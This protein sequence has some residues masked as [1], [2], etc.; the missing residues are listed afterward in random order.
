ML[1]SLFLLVS[2]FHSPTYSQATSSLKTANYEMDIRLDIENKKLYGTTTLLWNNP[3]ADEIT[4]LPMHLYYN[5]FRNSQS[6]FLKERGVPDFLTKNIDSECGWGW[7]QIV[8]IT[9]EYGNDLTDGLHYIQTDD[10]NTEDKS[11]IKIPLANTVGPYGSLSVTF[12][13][14]AKIP[15]T[16]P[17]TG[18]NKDFY[19]FAQWF[20][21]V[22][23][24]EPA[25]TRYAAEGAWNCHQ[26]HSNGEYYSDF[27]VY[28][29]HL[30]VP[31][32]YIVAASGALKNTSQNGA[33]K[34]WNFVVENVID[35]TW[36]CSPHYVVTEDKY[37]TTELKVY[38]YPEKQHFT[39]RYL[40]TIKFTMQYLEEHLGPYPYPTL[41]IIDPPI[42]G[43]YTGGMEYPTLITCLSFNSF[44]K[45]FKTPETLI[46]HEYIHQYFMQMVATHE[47]EE[48]WM[49]EGF[50]TYYEGRILDAYMTDNTSTVEFLGLKAGNKEWNRAEFFGNENPQ[51][52]ANTRKSWQYKHGGYGVISYNKTA[53][54]LQT[55]ER[56][57]GIKT[58]DE[59][60]KTY[61][62]RWQYKH[63]A[64]QDYIDIVNEVVLKNHASEYPKGMD[65]YFDQVL[66][67][68]GL[69]DYA[70][71][72][73]ENLKKERVR[74]YFSDLDHCEAHDVA[75]DNYLSTIILHRLGEIKIPVD[76]QV[77]LATGESTLYSWDGQDRSSEI[78]IEGIEKVV[79]V[80]IDPER[81]IYLDKNFLNNSLLIE[82]QPKGIRKIFARL[83]TSTLHVFETLAI[84]I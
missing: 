49:D 44:P 84:L 66:Y 41:S 26:Y 39:D 32:D 2:L 42:H 77:T 79:S 16:M 70:V 18:Y 81:K 80:E 12:D 68:T 5:A 3:S 22:G 48:P 63:P 11:V 1:F 75:D 31:E 29:V 24:Y 67:G 37:K 82:K 27:G 53:L 34:T 76:V 59:I 15:Q 55:M 64:R 61:F 69:C 56:L 23:V 4:Y 35:F 28:D 54:W 51:I 30:T 60:M 10:N 14:E 47:V 62:T 17:R 25:G 73:I 74:G 8:S 20:P 21:K 46:V 43:L 50:T 71:A 57:L 33:M 72:S 19:F 13:W 83:L 65:W 52:A 7:T 38:S 58:M 36:S 40:P 6:T 9:D 45:G 78:I